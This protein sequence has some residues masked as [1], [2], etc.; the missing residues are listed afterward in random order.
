MEA[1]DKS[2]CS[3][4][5]CRLFEFLESS[6]GKKIMVALAGF[7]LCGFLIT[8]LAGNM[9]MF[10]GANAFNHYAEVLEGNPFLPVAEIGLVVLFL[11]HIVLTIRAKFINMA[12]RPV[13][14][15]VY[16]GK[17]ARTPGSST[18]VWTGMLIL[19]FIVIHVA[20][21]KFDIGG[22]KGPTLFDHVLGWFKN[23]FYAGFYVL[24][25]AG[26][27]LHLSHGVQSAIQ[28][29]GVNHP[30]YTPLLKKLG[31]LFALAITIGFGSLPVYFG[32]IHHDMA[33]CAAMGG[34]K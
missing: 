31:L 22:E 7:L 9:F 4:C 13:A 30:R 14:Y 33:C 28:T 11:L 18:M 19:T 29:I 2:C 10:V 5:S 21:L 20:T 27:G 15:E 3:Q 8:H 12:A 16:Q 32:F 34:A 23:P 26:V 1:K 17:G 24:A 25:V 6:I